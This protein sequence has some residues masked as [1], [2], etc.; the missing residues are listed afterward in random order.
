MR[1][2]YEKPLIT[3]KKYGQTYLCNHPIYNRCTLFKIR[4]KG[5]C[6][7]QQR[8]DPRTKKCWWSEIDP[9]L[10][11]SIYLHP[12][13]KEYFD[14]RSGAATDGLYP[15]VTIRQLMWALKM[16]PIRRERWETYFDRKDI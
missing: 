10:L 12:R 1:Y 7:I 2:H 5:I 11:D 8:F 4:D 6:V 16:K 3:L 15:T 13:F 14:E 9:W